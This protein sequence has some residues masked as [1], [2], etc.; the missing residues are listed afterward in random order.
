MNRFLV[1]KSSRRFPSAGFTV[2]D[3][4]VSVAILGIMLTFVLANFRAAKTSGDLDVVIKR[5]V[6]GITT[7]RNMSLGGQLTNSSFPEG[8]YGIHFDFD[9]PNR[10]ILFLAA[11]AGNSYIPNVNGLSNGIVEFDGIKLT[12]VCGHKELQ[13]NETL[14]LPCTD[15]WQR[16]NWQTAGD[17]M[18]IKFLAYNEMAINY[19]NYQLSDDFKYIGGVVSQEKTGQTGYFYVSLVSGLISGD[20]KR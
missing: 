5:I 2:I 20:L 17:F 12:E 7:V 18:E 14:G 10:Y 9:N 19:S 3:L 8:G 11:V 6:D 16:I 4:L 13:L 1:K 15:S